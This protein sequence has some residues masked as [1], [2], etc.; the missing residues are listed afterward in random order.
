M[1]YVLHPVFCIAALATVLLSCPVFAQEDK[2]PAN[3]KPA[4]IVIRFKAHSMHASDFQGRRNKDRRLESEIKNKG[5]DVA[6]TE[7][8]Q[9]DHPFI[10]AKECVKQVGE[11]ATTFKTTNHMIDFDLLMQKRSDLRVQVAK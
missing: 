10:F 9:R 11:M 2:K 7:W 4:P 8:M 3:V 6:Y 1:K 5:I